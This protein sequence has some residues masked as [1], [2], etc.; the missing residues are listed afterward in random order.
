MTSTRY[1]RFPPGIGNILVPLDDRRAALAALSLYSP[2]LQSRVIAHRLT[3]QAV[4]SFGAWA[5]PGQTITNL[6]E[7][8][9]AGLEESAEE[10][11]SMHGPIDSVIVYVARDP[12][13]RTWSF[14]L[15]R[16][17]MP[18]LWVKRRD[19]TESARL[20]HEANALRLTANYPTPF[21]HPHVV[22]VS[23]TTNHAYLT[24]TSLPL[25]IRKPAAVSDL[26]S[27]TESISAALRGLPK[28][29]DC[30]PEWRPS[31]GDLTPWNL[32]AS[33]ARS[34]VVLVDWEDAKWAPPGADLVLYRVTSTVLGLKAGTAAEWRSRDYSEAR[35]WWLREWTDRLNDGRRRDEHERVGDERSR[36]I[37]ARE[38]IDVLEGVAP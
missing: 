19:A 17:G 6:S 18:S 32:R 26:G 30:P 24:T 25:T 13:V 4:R 3:W 34:H 20:H 1:R 36:S 29:S 28:P 16:A 33:H 14:L 31:H 23:E 7:V 11:K 35:E 38:V 21:Q 12:L 5:V 2:C 15:L 8:D 37:F 10:V 22:D 9:A 27:L